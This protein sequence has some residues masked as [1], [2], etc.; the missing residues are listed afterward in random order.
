MWKKK[1]KGVAHLGNY[2]YTRSGKRVFKLKHKRTGR[3]K[4]FRSPEHAKS[5]GWRKVS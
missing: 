2:E 4:L 1:R 5:E 3:E